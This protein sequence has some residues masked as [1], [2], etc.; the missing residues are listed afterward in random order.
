MT[1]RYST[2]HKV[3]LI[4]CP[5]PQVGGP[6][7]GRCVGRA[8]LLLLWWVWYHAITQ[9]LAHASWPTQWLCLPVQPCVELH[10]SNDHQT[11]TTPT[12]VAPYAD[13]GGSAGGEPDRHRATLIAAT[14][15]VVLVSVLGFGWATQPLMQVRCRAALRW[16]G[17]RLPGMP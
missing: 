11:H 14:L 4:P 16:D 15:V 7:E 10:P 9:A 12:P 2:L 5:P 3:M 13:I 17:A 1:V 8:R 6:H